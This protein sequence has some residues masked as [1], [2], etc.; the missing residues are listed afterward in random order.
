MLLLL[1]HHFP[2]V[3]SVTSCRWVEFTLNSI[4]YTQNFLGRFTMWSRHTGSHGPPRLYSGC[5]LACGTSNTILF[6]GWFG[7]GYEMQAVRGFLDHPCG[8]L[9]LLLDHPRGTL[10]LLLLLLHDITRLGPPWV[11]ALRSVWR[12]DASWWKTCLARRE[13]S[14]SILL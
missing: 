10:C 4:M 14:L 12:R 1:L 11:C 5:R 2:L 3:V 13:T 9:C 6:T 8:T 7:G